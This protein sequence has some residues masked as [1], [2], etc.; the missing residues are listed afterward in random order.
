MSKDGSAK[1]P[2]HSSLATKLLVV[3][4]GLLLK[5]PVVALC[6]AVG[7]AI[8]AVILTTTGLGY[9]SSRLDLLNPRSDYNRLW[10]E[11]INEFGNEDDAVVVVEGASR[12][13]VVPVLQEIS[14]QLSREQNLFHA[15]LHEVDL[16]KI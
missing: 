8:A 5:F 6:A 4:T 14:T 7:L 9:K 15:V 11:Y 10:I 1:G 2:S 13:A 16:S 12:D 3:V